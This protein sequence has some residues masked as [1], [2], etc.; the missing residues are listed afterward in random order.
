MSLDKEAGEKS[1]T[2]I[3]L[4]IILQMID[5]QTCI[6]IFL[7]LYLPFLRYRRVFIGCKNTL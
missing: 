7:C 5:L 6:A 2:K 3:R 1:M 4:D